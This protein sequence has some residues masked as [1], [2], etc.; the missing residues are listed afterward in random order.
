[1]VQPFT[2]SNHQL[3]QTYATLTLN[4]FNHL[5]VQTLTILTNWF[6]YLLV[7]LPA[8]PF[9]GLKSYCSKEKLVQP[10]TVPTTNWFKHLLSDSNT[11]CWTLQASHISNAR[12]K[13]RPLFSAILMAISGGN[14]RPSFL[15]TQVKIWQICKQQSSSNTTSWWCYLSFFNR[16]CTDKHKND[17]PRSTNIPILQQKMLR[18]T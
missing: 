12:R 6:N 18:Q 2:G 9:S 17:F 1:M 16:Q 8:H 11:Y 14:V 4:W 13:F 5:L 15:Q 10:C 3:V 7:H